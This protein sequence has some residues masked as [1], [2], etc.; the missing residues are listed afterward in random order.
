MCDIPCI[1]VKMELSRPKNS[2]YTDCIT[3]LDEAKQS[4]MIIS[5]NH[6][7]ILWLQILVNTY[8]LVAEII[9]PSRGLNLKNSVV[10]LS[11]SS[12]RKLN[13]QHVM[14][15]YFWKR[16]VFLG[17]CAPCL[18]GIKL[19]RQDTRECLLHS[20]SDLSYDL[21]LRLPRFS[22]NVSACR[23]PPDVSRRFSDFQFSFSSRQMFFA[24]KPERKR[25]RSCYLVCSAPPMV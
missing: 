10:L 6:E 16:I 7:V 2:V 22:E 12:R 5:L 18:L 17:I 23:S 25:A 19:S 20:R 14:D 13:L 24:Q 11:E 9:R 3:P 15:L 21:L 4:K 8:S 1:V